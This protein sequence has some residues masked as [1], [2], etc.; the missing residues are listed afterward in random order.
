MHLR[1]PMVTLLS[2]MQGGGSVV[3]DPVFIVA[4]IAGILCLLLVCYEILG[5]ISSLTII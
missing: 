1:P 5:V 3:V 2:V 4:P